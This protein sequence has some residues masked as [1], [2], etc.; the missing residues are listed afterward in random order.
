MKSFVAIILVSI[1][2]I[3]ITSAQSPFPSKSASWKVMQEWRNGPQVSKELAKYYYGSDTIVV[4]SRAFLEM[5]YYG[6][7]GPFGKPGPYIYYDSLSKKVMYLSDYTDTIPNCL[8]DFSLSIGD[9]LAVDVPGSS[10]TLKWHVIDTITHDVGTGIREGLLVEQNYYGYIFQDIWIEGIGSIHG[11]FTPIYEPP[12]TFEFGYHLVCFTDSS[13]G[14]QFAPDIFQD[15]TYSCA[16]RISLPEEPSFFAEDVDI[17]PNPFSQK[18]NMHNRGRHSVEITI[19]TARGRI[20]KRLLLAPGA[21]KVINS[22]PWP[23]GVYLVRIQ[24]G[25]QTITRKVVRGG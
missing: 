16:S 4:S 3:P 17:F 6:Y 18:L 15:S 12:Y 1:V 8:Y 24:G 19:A 20:M 9:T 7:A 11:L 23:A 10:L 22:S 2:I 13:T 5:K 25:G 21:H 14:F